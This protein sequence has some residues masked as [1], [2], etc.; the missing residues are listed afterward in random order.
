VAWAREDVRASSR[1]F[2][3]AALNRQE[4]NPKRPGHWEVTLVSY[5]T[6]GEA[7][8]YAAAGSVAVWRQQVVL[9]QSEQPEER[10]DP[11]ARFHFSANV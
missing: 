3:L 9:E 8:T 7:T 11:T 6:I 5:L 4:T 10:A 1:Y 2:Q